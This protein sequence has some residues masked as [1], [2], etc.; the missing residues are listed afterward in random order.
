MSVRK[1]ITRVSY[2]SA[3]R[4]YNKHYTYNFTIKT[5]TRKHI[6]GKAIKDVGLVPKRGT[7]FIS[8]YNDN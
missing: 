4:N 5:E 1:I 7:Y 3:F 8:A 6:E 2:R